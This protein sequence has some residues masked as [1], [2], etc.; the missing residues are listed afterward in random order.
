MHLLKLGAF[1]G[2]SELI[3]RKERKGKEV[4]VQVSN[5]PS[6]KGTPIG[7]TVN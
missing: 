3:K 7:D 5:L 4:Y 1:L 2:I 6:V